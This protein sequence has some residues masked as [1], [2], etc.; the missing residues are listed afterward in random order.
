MKYH[1]LFLLLFS[2]GDVYAQPEQSIDVALRMFHKG[3]PVPA[4]W[5]GTKYRFYDVKWKEQPVEDFNHYA[6]LDLAA[7]DVPAVLHIVRVP[8]DTMTLLLQNKLPYVADEFRFRKGRFDLGKGLTH[9]SQRDAAEMLVNEIESDDRLWQ[10]A[11][12]E[13]K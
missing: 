2:T 9:T 4:E 7:P 3:R 12:I 1:L 5:L 10:Q 6:R 11:L 13:Y 8:A